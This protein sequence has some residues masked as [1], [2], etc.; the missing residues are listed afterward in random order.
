MFQCLVNLNNLA[1]HEFHDKPPV[2]PVCH[3]KCGNA[4]GDYEHTDGREDDAEAHLVLP[5]DATAHHV[6]VYAEQPVQ[7]T[8]V[9]A[10]GEHERE[11][12]IVKPMPEGERHENQLH[13]AHQQDAIHDHHDSHQHGCHSEQHPCGAPH[14]PQSFVTQSFQHTERFK[15]ITNG[16]PVLFTGSWFFYAE[17]RRKE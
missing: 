8:V 10:I 6:V 14:P 2:S 1:P 4:Q 5:P 17:F 13:P 9:I 7:R 15:D 16:N 3:N 12:E 11:Y